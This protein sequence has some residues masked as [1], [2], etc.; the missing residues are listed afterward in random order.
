MEQDN[1]HPV[2]CCSAHQHNT[3]SAACLLYFG[4]RTERISEKKDAKAVAASQGN[5]SDVE[6]DNETD[7][8]MFQAFFHDV[9]DDVAF[10]E[11]AEIVYGFIFTHQDMFEKPYI[12][13][14]YREVDKSWS[15]QVSVNAGKLD[16]KDQPIKDELV[17]GFFSFD[18]F[19]SV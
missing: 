2:S 14:M 10:M 12:L 3:K 11:C 17:R 16:P 13:L 7:E 5:A 15:C 19:A 1:L 8:S 18:P 6:S 4:C 9:L